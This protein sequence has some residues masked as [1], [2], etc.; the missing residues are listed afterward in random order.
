MKTP[1]VPSIISKYK[2]VPQKRLGQHFLS[3]QPTMEKIVGALE[4]A[5]TDVVVEIGSGLGIMTAMLA[6][7]CKR[8][9]AVERDTGLLEVARTEFADIKNIEW[10]EGDVLKL[11]IENIFRRNAG[12]PERRNVKIIGNLPYNISSP[13]LFWMLDNRAMISSAL[14]LLQK[15]VATRLVARPGNRDYGILSVLIQAHAECKKVFDVSPSNF[16][17]PP[18]VDSSVVRIEF[19]DRGRA[20]LD[21][22]RFKATVKS[23]FG[24]RRK[25]LRNALLG[26]KDLRLGKGRIDAALAGCGIDGSRRPETLSVEEF[27]EVARWLYIIPA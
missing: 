19:D 23:A 27:I 1:S 5:G 14:V 9:V 7:R 4:V 21:E 22:E 16:I 12:S 20:I 13:V 2:I 24:R 26:A 15:E 17:P 8:V 6:G 11:N 3:A 18:Q 25:T 10:L